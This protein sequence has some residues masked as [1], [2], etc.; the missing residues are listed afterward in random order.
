MCTV[1]VSLWA[2]LWME[3][4]QMA[5]YPQRN[6]CVMKF[7]HCQTVIGKITWANLSRY[8]QIYRCV[9]VY[10]WGEGG[11]TPRLT[12][13]H[14]G[15]AQS[16]G[17]EISARLE[18][19]YPTCILSGNY[20][21]PSAAKA[22]QKPD[23]KTFQSQSTVSSSEP[24]P[25][26]FGMQILNPH[27]QMLTAPDLL[28]ITAGRLSWNHYRLN[29]YTDGGCCIQRTYDTPPNVLQSHAAF[30]SSNP[31]L[32]LYSLILPKSWPNFTPS[33]FLT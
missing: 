21:A 9:S 26:T 31:I 6:K 7:Q 2:Y 10:I 15:C 32:Q 19:T 16:P 23:R 28:T 11:W 13:G 30:Q 20:R 12:P 14:Y 8:I 33:H 25:S 27:P 18:T 3:K 24:F 29:T 5:F 1:P 17:L 4:V 22:L